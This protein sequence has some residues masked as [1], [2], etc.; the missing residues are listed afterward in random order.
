MLLKAKSYVTIELDMNDNGN[1]ERFFH[2]GFQ[3]YKENRDKRFI[4]KFI[5]EN[6]LIAS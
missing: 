3:I 2:N 6:N 1:A 4:V 5:E